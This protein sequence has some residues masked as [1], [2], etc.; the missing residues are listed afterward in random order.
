MNSPCPGAERAVVIVHGLGGGAD[1]FYCRAAARRLHARGWTALNLALRGADL[2]GTDYYHGALTADVHAA[3]ADLARTHE[4]V[5][6]LGF[7]VGGHIA[8]HVACESEDARLLSVAAISAPLDLTVSSHYIDSPRASFYRRHVLAGCKRVYV[9]VSARASVPTPV[10]EVLRART[11]HELDS[12]TVV[13]RFDYESTSEYYRHASVAPLLAE[14]PR[15]ALYVGAI[16]DPMV[17]QHLVRPFFPKDS[18]NFEVRMV[19]NGG[20]VG[21]PRTLDLGLA[22][23]PGLVEQVIGFFERS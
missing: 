15:P 21:F 19:R 18:P 12:L 4:K 1:S 20:H 3:V 22:P 7:S 14:L 10:E 23:D 9:A 5:H 2:G 6:V 17:P 8:L 16:H 11:L 13:P